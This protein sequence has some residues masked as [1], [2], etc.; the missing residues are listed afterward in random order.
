RIVVCTIAGGVAEYSGIGH[1]IA[2]FFLI[3]ICL[4]FGPALLR[5]L[6]RVGKGAVFAGAIAILLTLIA[7][8]QA[9][10]LDQPLN[11]WQTLT[12]NVPKDARWMAARVAIG[13]LPNVG[14]FGFGPGTFRVVFPSYN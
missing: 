10:H 3:A 13:A 12:Q 8:A 11:R 9:A 7:V 2:L 6:S 5:K 1:L 14:L 4:K